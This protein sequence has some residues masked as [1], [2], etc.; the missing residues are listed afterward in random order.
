MKKYSETD[1]LRWSELMTSAQQG[2]EKDYRQLLSELGNAIEAYVRLR[3]GYSDIVEDC[4]QESLIAIH[5][6]RDTYESSRL[7]RPW[8]FAIVNYKTIDV[9]RKREQQQR[10]VEK[11]NNCVD[12]EEF[13]SQDQDA[14]YER[15]QECGQVLSA[16]PAIYRDALLLTK[17]Q[18]LSI[19]EAAKKLDISESALKVRVHRALDAS[20][21]LLDVE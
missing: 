15:V 12:T 2:N 11:Q 4:V 20:R 5:K 21:Q 3:F 14:K 16:L 8:L 18:G 9:L 19:K 6:A 1:E 17:L 7:F 13:M 10:V